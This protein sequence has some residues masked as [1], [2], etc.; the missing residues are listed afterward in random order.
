M[1][2][3][4]VLT[5]DGLVE[6]PLRLSFGD[7]D[8][9]PA[10]ADLPEDREWTWPGGYPEGHLLPLRSGG[11]LLGA[12]FLGFEE[13]SSFHPD[14]PAFVLWRRQLEAALHGLR[15]A[16]LHGAGAGA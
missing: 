11:M 12:L 10:P 7:L 6:R 8:A 3:D 2:A 13:R 1:K 9:L 5:I 15:R 4:V 14:D 16:R